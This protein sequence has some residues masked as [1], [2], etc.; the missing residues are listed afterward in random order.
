[1]FNPKTGYKMINFG[2]IAINSLSS[3][4]FLKILDCIKICIQ[5]EELGLNNLSQ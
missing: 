2:L 1:M 3:K 5:L 4:V